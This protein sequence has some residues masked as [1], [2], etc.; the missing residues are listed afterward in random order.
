MGVV[1][2]MGSSISEEPFTA[3]A[4]MS[5]PP[6]VFMGTLNHGFVEGDP[7]TPP[8]QAQDPQSAQS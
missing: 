8:L 4:W 1:R 2:C 7:R 3:L 5:S 6:H